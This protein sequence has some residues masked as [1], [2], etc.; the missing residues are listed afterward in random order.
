MARPIN[1]LAVDAG[2]GLYWQEVLTNL[3]RLYPL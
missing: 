3:R 2:M 1:R